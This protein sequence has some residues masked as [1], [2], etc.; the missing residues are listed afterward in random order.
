MSGVLLVHVLCDF[1][2]KHVPCG[3]VVIQNIGKFV[4]ASELSLLPQQLPKLSFSVHVALS[5]ITVC[6]YK[7]RS[8]NASIHLHRIWIVGTLGISAK[9]LLHAEYFSSK[10]EVVGRLL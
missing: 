2:I 6:T 10:F 1:T 4:Q 9:L 3:M 7:A 5:P 8:F